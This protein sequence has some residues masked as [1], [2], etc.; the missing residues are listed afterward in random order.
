MVQR[1]FGIAELFRRGRRQVGLQR[2]SIEIAVR[3]EHG[4]HFRY[5]E[6]F[7]DQIGRIFFD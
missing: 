2:Q 1:I 7:A 4:E 3:G 5:G 6:M